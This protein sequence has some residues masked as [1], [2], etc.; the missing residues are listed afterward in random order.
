MTPFQGNFFKSVPVPSDCY[1][2]KYILHDWSDAEC[3]TILQK[4]L[5]AMQPGGKVVVLEHVVPGP[6]ESDTA[7]TVWMDVNMM[8]GICG[9][10]VPR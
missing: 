7:G 4:V 2:M 6:G 5:E 8:V 3:V 1:V 9:G 10:V